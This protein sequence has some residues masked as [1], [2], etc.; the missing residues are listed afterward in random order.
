MGR[1]ILSR[2]AQNNLQ[3]PR[4]ANHQAASFPHSDERPGALKHTF[5]R[6]PQI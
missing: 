2:D 3:N 1:T 4:S 5:S 6:N